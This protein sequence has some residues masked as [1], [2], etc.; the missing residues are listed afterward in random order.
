MTS[1]AGKGKKES[2]SVWFVT[3]KAQGKTTYALQY[4]NG[5]PH[6]PA[7]NQP[8][9]RET[10]ILFFNL[11]KIELLTACVGEVFSYDQYAQ[12]WVWEA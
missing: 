1:Y 3:K 11:R 6:F 7:T 12:G 9:P 10:H 8:C 4:T 5:P 2:V